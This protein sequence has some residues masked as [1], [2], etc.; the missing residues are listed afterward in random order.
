M[1]LMRFTEHALTAI[2]SVAASLSIV[3]LTRPADLPTGIVT[4]NATDAV[5]GFINDGR[6][7]MDEATYKAEVAKFQERLDRAVQEIAAENNVIVVNSAVVLGGAPDI[8]PAIV[9]RVTG[10]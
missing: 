7:D 10:Q 5:M 4:I 2:V 8:T 6:R 3:L 1:S 9:A